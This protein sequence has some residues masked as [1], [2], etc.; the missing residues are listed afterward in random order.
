M[1]DND[2]LRQTFLQNDLKW[3]ERNDPVYLDPFTKV[4]NR[5]AYDVFLPRLMDEARGLGI[6][7]AFSILDIDNFKVYNDRYGRAAGDEVVRELIGKVQSEILGTDYLFKYGGDELVF[8]FRDV[9]AKGALGS[10]IPKMRAAVN[11]AGL[12]A[13]I[14]TTDLQE[15]D[16]AESI[17]ERADGFMH[18]EKENKKNLKN[19]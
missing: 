8:I 3:V 16:T 1:N 15:V 19:G 5:G 2:T 14:G 11:D 7:L 12:E 17:F 9:S 10:I 4:L 6:P 18:A 13:S